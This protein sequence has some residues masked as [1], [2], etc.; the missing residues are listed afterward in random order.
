[1]EGLVGW[2]MAK[3]ITFPYKIFFVPRTHFLVQILVNFG[4]NLFWREIE[5]DVRRIVDEKVYRKV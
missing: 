4:G 2:E 3:G 1:M 5:R